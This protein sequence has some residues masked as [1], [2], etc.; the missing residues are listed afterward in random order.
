MAVHMASVASPPTVKMKKYCSVSFPN[1]RK[2]SI[3][4]I[5]CY[6]LGQIRLNKQCR[7]KQLLEE[8]SDQGLYCFLQNLRHISNLIRAHSVCSHPLAQCFDSCMY[9]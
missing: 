7:F 9:L 2:N 5:E 4:C 3:I 6:I 8:Q 1:G